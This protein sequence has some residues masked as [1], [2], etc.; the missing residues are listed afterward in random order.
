MNE[1]VHKLGDYFS[2]NTSVD[3]N[4]FLS[5]TFFPILKLTK[6]LFQFNLNVFIVNVP[7]ESEVFA[8]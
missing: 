4:R 6:F 2:F 8:A 5:S 3:L 7:I 1:L